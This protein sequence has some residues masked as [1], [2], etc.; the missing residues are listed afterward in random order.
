MTCHVQV[1]L[2]NLISFNLVTCPLPLETVCNQSGLDRLEYKLRKG[3]IRFSCES[4]NTLVTDISIFHS[5]RKSR[6]GLNLI[7]LQFWSCASICTYSDVHP[8][9]SGA[10]AARVFSI[11]CDIQG[12]LRKKKKIVSGIFK[13]H[14]RGELEVFGVMQ[15]INR[16][17]CSPGEITFGGFQ[18]NAI[19]LSR[20]TTLQLMTS[21][22]QR[23]K[24]RRHSITAMLGTI[25]WT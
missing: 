4:P 23:V 16:H 25:T 10:S 2:P 5:I 9:E 14:I 3:L 24:W 11:S 15:P 18:L 12:C 17:S 6:S 13:G 21:G 8:T 1:S 20:S 19:T 7:L 22:R